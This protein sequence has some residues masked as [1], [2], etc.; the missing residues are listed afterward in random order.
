MP[1][2]DNDL[3][4]TVGGE[5]LPD[6]I[7]TRVRDGLKDMIQRELQAKAGTLTSFHAAGHS[8]TQPTEA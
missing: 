1:N 4:I 5:R 7:H 3:E 6:E 8:S 2:A